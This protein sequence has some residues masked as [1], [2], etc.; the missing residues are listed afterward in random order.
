MVLHV[1]FLKKTMTKKKESV[2]NIVF[3]VFRLATYKT[4]QLEFNGL[5]NTLMAL[6][7][8]GTL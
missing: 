4:L 6:I 5:I 2:Q 3:A 8:T 7:E 1:G